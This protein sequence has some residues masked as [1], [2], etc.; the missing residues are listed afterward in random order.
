MLHLILPTPVFGSL[1]QWQFALP[2]PQ[3]DMFLISSFSFSHSLS[4]DQE[5]RVL[6]CLWVPRDLFVQPEA[7]KGLEL[8][9]TPLLQ[10]I[11]TPNLCD[12]GHDL[13]DAECR[14]SFGLC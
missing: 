13:V 9:I 8:I 1:T 14:V 6:F 5:P 12:V 2:W 4:R 11:I 3:S 7:G 10:L